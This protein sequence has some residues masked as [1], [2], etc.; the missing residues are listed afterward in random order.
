MV[1]GKDKKTNKTHN[2]YFLI[3]HLNK[4]IKTFKRNKLITE[5]LNNDMN[6]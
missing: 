1:Q 6:L 3:M 4:L 5:R 2:L